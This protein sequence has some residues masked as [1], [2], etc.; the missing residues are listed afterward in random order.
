MY[1]KWKIILFFFLAILFTNCKK[2][3]ITI[4]VD[5]TCEDIPPISGIS[6]GYQY[7]QPEIT[8]KAPCFNPTNPNELIFVRGHY[9]THSN[10]LVKYNLISKQEN[11]LLNS[12]QIWGRPSWGKNG[13]I[14]LNKG[15]NQVWKIKDNGDSLIQLTTQ[16]G[17]D[18]IWSPNANEFAYWVQIGS[19]YYTFFS[20][21]N[22]NVF[23]T[24]LYPNIVYQAAWSPDGSKIATHGLS[25][26]DLNTQQTIF[27]STPNTSYIQSVGWLSDSETLIWN[28]NDGIFLTN[29]F[30]QKTSQ[31]KSACTSKFY[32]WF[33]VH[34]NSNKIIVERI[35]NTLIN[36][37]TIFS[38]NNLYIMD[39]DGKNETKL[40]L[41]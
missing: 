6:F 9:S 35:D 10:E 5:K 11:I 16:F 40:T 18:A 17:L 1:T 36:D 8:S 2:D 37:Y 20:D 38:E 19:I 14:L 27:V 34:P 41:P 7:T 3:A 4:V 32:S 31:I 39:V 21:V 28:S 26:I 30:S 25:Y 23:D 13:W 29:I 15:D 24:L 33:T 22:G 12:T